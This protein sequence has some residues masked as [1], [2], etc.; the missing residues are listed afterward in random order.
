M[1]RFLRWLDLMFNPKY[2]FRKDLYQKGF[3]SVKGRQLDAIGG[4]MQR[5]YKRK[6]KKKK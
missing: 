2:L 4:A 5:Q 6:Q 1:N 3:R